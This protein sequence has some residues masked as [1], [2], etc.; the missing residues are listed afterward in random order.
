MKRSEL[1]NLAWTE[2]VVKIAARFGMSDRGFAKLCARHHIPLP[3]RGY[4]AK[5]KVGQ[6]PAR[7]PLPRPDQDYEIPLREAASI[8]A[9]GN[10]SAADLQL[11]MQMLFHSKL[12]PKAAT[13]MVEG[14]AEHAP[15]PDPVANVEMLRVPGRPRGRPRRCPVEDFAA[16]ESSPQSNEPPTQPALSSTEPVRPVTDLRALDVEC[17]RAMTAG[18]EYLRRQAAQA[19]LSA[20]AAAANDQDEARCTALLAWVRVV[21]QR[22]ALRDPVAAVIDQVL[23]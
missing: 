4:W 7:M 22:L 21:H 6:Y 18:M 11:T 1:F 13:Q 10:E 15:A 23:R 12:T 16:V 8:G 5:V 2:P 19:L 14:G 17:E 9:Q 3:E 20:V